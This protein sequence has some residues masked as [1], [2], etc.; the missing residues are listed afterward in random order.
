MG[1][2]FDPSKTEMT[3]EER[4]GMCQNGHKWLIP[5]VIFNGQCLL[6][7]RGDRGLE[8]DI[9]PDCGGEDRSGGS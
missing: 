3:R 4:Q 1:G 8:A 7:D 6:D 5:L 9:C 2:L